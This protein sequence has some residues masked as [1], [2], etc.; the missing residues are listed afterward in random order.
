MMN[1]SEVYPSN[2]P[3]EVNCM[4]A[5]SSNQG[6]YDPRNPILLQ[7]E[8]LKPKSSNFLDYSTEMDDLK[9]LDV[10]DLP[11]SSANTTDQMILAGRALIR[12]V[13]RP[14]PSN[15]VVADAISPLEPPRPD[16][17]GHCRS[18]YWGDGGTDPFFCDIEDLS[19]WPALS[20][21]PIF[22]KIPDDGHIIPFVSSTLKPQ[23]NQVDKEAR[24]AEEQSDEEIANF[25]DIKQKT[26]ASD[27]M[28]SLD[29]ALSA[30]RRV[31]LDS[32]GD[33]NGDTKS[34][35]PA[36]NETKELPATLRISEATTTVHAPTRTLTHPSQDDRGPLSP[37]LTD[38]LRDRS[39]TWKN[40]YHN[41]NSIS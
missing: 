1:P 14:L 4:V 18:K 26:E 20:T 13:G 36:L 34:Q 38:S 30:R 25:K 23:V 19:D 17:E 22:W 2:E 37:G 8:F 5:E 24:R 40:K 21:D 32:S 12:L 9:L 29:R 28:D 41:T 15:F 39:P 11:P 7:P 16:D 27:I 31:R 10:P 33:I 35:A 3:Y 6:A